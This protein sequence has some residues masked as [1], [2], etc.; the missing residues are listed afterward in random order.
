MATATKRKRDSQDMPGMRPAPGM[1]QDFDTSSYLQG[2]DGTMDSN[3]NNMDFTL[4]AQHNADGGEDVDIQQHTQLQNQQSH[5]RNQHDPQH[6]HQQHNQ[7]QDIS[8]SSNNQ[9]N[10]SGQSA[11]DTATAALAQYHTMTVPQPTEHSF[12]QT[13]G[14]G[15]SGEGQG[16]S[17]GDGDLQRTN[18]YDGGQ[19]TL[20]EAIKDAENRVQSNGAAAGESSPPSASKPAVGS[21]EWHK[22]RRDNHKEGK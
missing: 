9:N 2:D 22:V 16:S 17:G 7:Q 3:E 8:D 14:G 15:D 19:F 6:Q 20:S 21:E 18:S 13:A 5:H 1:H 12:M 10:N 4:L 11:T